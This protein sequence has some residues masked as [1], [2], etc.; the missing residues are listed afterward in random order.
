MIEIVYYLTLLSPLTE[1]LLDDH[2]TITTNN[3]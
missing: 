1:T 3:K 2:W